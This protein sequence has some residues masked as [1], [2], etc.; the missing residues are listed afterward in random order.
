MRYQWE[1]ATMN[2]KLVTYNF[3]HTNVLKKLYMFNNALSFASLDFI[4]N[5]NFSINA[6]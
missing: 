5:I 1:K 4:I 6:L 2:K 3:S